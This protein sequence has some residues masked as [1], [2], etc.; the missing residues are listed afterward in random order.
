[1]NRRDL[2]AAGSLTLLGGG[3]GTALGLGPFGAPDE[4]TADYQD[5]ASIVADHDRLDLRLLDESVR[6]GET[7][8]FAVTNTGDEQVSLGCNVPWALQRRADDGWRHVAWTG[9]RYVQLCYTGL[10]PGRSHVE[11]VPLTESELTARTDGEA[12]D[13]VPDQYRFVL[14][15]PVV[16][17]ACEFAVDE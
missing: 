13:L 8:R 2:L 16:F 17:L 5:D 3:V 7:A 1:M 10:G 9:G 4:S 11:H 14:L 15:S 6:L 12:V